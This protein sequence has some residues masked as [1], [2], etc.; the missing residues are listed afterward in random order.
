[1]LTGFILKEKNVINDNFIKAANFIV[2]YVALPLKLFNSVLAS[3]VADNFNLKFMSFIITLTIISVILVWIVALF[4]IKEKS[5]KGAFIHAGFR[6]NFVY[7][8]LSLLENVTGS[9]GS[10]AP[11]IIAFIIPLYNILAVLVLTFTNKN[12][13]SGNNLLNSL[14]SMLKNPFIIAIFL[15]IICSLTGFELPNLADNT[16]QYFSDLATPLALVTIGATFN[17]QQLFANIMPSLIASL[18]KLVFLPAVMVLSGLLFSFSN[19][20]L[21]LIYILFGVPSA[22]VSYIMTAAM[23]GDREL[24][25]SIVMMTTLLSVITMTVFV[26]IFKTIGM[27]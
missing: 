25:A 18:V 9:I 19:Y 20:E 14:K 2:F 10:V 23:G 27:V 7:V 26:F 1:M 24:A 21:F 15:G 5:K 13:K 12:N 11:L 22:T 8:G 17:L 6:G 16:V 3:N 4:F